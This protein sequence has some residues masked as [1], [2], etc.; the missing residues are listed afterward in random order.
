MRK[1]HLEERQREKGEKTFSKEEENIL[2][3]KREREREDDRR[4][5]KEG[6][7]KLPLGMRIIITNLITI[8]F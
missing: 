5:E 3:K 1:N 7:V 6:V 4:R 2:L 8:Q